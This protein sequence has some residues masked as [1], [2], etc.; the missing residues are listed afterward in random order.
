[1]ILDGGAGS[2]VEFMSGT[3][4]IPMNRPDIAVAHALAGQYLGMELI[5]LEAG[6]G[7]KKPVGVDII[8]QVNE[9]VDIPLIVGGGI[10]TPT[11]AAERVEAGAAIIVTGTVIER[12]LSLMKEF[13]DA[14]H[15][16]K[17]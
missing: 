16:K 7:A 8:K 11:V 1:M 13:A 3:R 9:A 15:W 2:T 6:S 12:N 10:R 17:L 14:I 4:P 5:Y